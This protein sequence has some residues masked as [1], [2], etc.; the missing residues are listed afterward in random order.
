MLIFPPGTQALVLNVNHQCFCTWCRVAEFL[1]QNRESQDKGPDWSVWSCNLDA[2]R[3]MRG[4]EHVARCRHFVQCLQYHSQSPKDSVLSLL[5]RG[6]RRRISSRECLFIRDKLARWL[7][8]LFPIRE[9]LCLTDRGKDRLVVPCSF[10]RH[11]R[12]RLQVHRF[13]WVTRDPCKHPAISVAR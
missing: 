10:V 11:R 5:Q 12:R 7:D 9:A 6:G 3:W 2:Q 4:Q 13:L 8:S 1:P